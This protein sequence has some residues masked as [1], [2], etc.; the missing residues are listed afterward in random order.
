LLDFPQL[1]AS[2]FPLILAVFENRFTAFGD[3]VR[4]ACR[5]LAELVAAHR[6]I[7]AIAVPALIRAGGAAAD[8]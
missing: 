3:L 1:K 5:L 7:V 4:K 2:Y 8:C 6:E